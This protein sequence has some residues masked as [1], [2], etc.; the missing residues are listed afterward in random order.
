MSRSRP[1][2]RHY[3]YRPLAFASFK[4]LLKP[5]LVRRLRDA[6]GNGRR[7][8]KL[9]LVPFL[10]LGVCVAAHHAQSG[11]EGIFEI[12]RSDTGSP[13]N[14]FPTVSAFSQYRK[15]FPLRVLRML[16]REITRRVAL[17]CNSD[18]P[19]RLWTMDATTLILPEDLWPLFGNHSGTQGHGPTQGMLLVLYDL[20]GRVP[21]GLRLGRGRQREK[22]LAESFWDR[23]R[24][25]DVVLLDAG[26]LSYRV[27]CRI[28][29]RRA[30]FL[31][32]LRKNSRPKRTVRLAAGDSLCRIERGPYWKRFTHLPETLSLRMVCSH[33]PGFRPR[34]LLTSLVDHE[35]FPAQSL[36]QLYHQ[37]WHVETFFRD[38]KYTLASQHWHARTL[39]GLYAELLFTMIL[40]S[41]TRLVMADAAVATGRQPGELSFSHALTKVTVAL[42]SLPRVPLVRWPACYR[43]LVR[44]VAQ[45]LIDIRPDRSFPR[46]TQKRRR[47]RRRKLL[48]QGGEHVL[49]KAA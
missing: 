2:V 15:R 35:K 6:M 45:C 7:Q 33:R 44:E 18:R 23:M 30:H 28:M 24:P 3:S 48:L 29:A 1:V 4:R 40:A 20:A 42:D 49:S 17:S 22:D 8:R 25:G 5:A 36:A 9:G 37:R 10:W 32:P 43:R 11:L 47:L 41:L 27:Y 31:M 38:F 46:D 14:A 39:R 13:R 19:G 16:W 26:F 21:L 34:W 12:A